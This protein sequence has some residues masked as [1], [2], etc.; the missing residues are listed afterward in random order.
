MQTSRNR[1]VLAGAVIWACVSLAYAAPAEQG[2]QPSA[3]AL[4]T[5]AIAAKAVVGDDINNNGV[6]DDVEEFLKVNTK[7]SKVRDAY[8]ELAKQLQRVIV[9]VPTGK[10]TATK[11]ARN[12]EL[13][14]VELGK[15]TAFFSEAPI[16][17][18]KLERL[19]FNT[20]ERKSAYE[21]FTVAFYRG[22]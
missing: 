1:T 4:R 19:V 7:S 18:S 6:R 3:T 22:Q 5:S 13:A 15:V 21:S 12:I 16:K 11:I 20:S 14:M 8:Q 17:I 10:S 2:A 9:E